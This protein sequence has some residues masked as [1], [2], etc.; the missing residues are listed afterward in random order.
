MNC[1]IEIH[2]GV[3]GDDAGLFVAELNRMYNKF[4]MKQG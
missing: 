2:R 1:I 4:A 3:G